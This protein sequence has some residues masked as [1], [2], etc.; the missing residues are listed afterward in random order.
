MKK[1]LPGQQR[2]LEAFIKAAQ[3]LAGLTTQQDIWSETGK[4]LVNFFGADVGA[5]E[6]GRA[7]RE[8][9]RHQWT[10]SKQFSSSRRDLEAATREIIAEAL[11]SG[12][13][14]TRIIFLPEALSLACFPV[15]RENQVVAVMLAGHG[16]SEALPRELL[17]V[18]L[19]MA[20]L[21]GT[22]VTRLTSERELREHREH[23][24]Q[25][26]K[27][28]TKELTKV[29]KQMQ[30]EISERKQAEKA[31]SRSEAYFR[32]LI[33][34]ASDMITILNADDIIRYESPSAER[35][36]G[37]KPSEMI[38]R[39]AFEFIHPDDLLMIR[40][41]GDR[42][43][44]IPG[45]TLSIEH[46][47]RHK[48]GSWRILE[49][50]VQN[51]L[52]N[53]AVKGIVVNSH[54][55]T[56][57]KMAEHDL[58]RERNHLQTLLDF[59]RR[60]DTH[61]K[62]IESFIIEEC[63][64]I[65]GSKL[66]FI[67]FIDEDETLMQTHF[68]SEKA[69]EECVIDFKPVE[70]SLVHAGIWAEAIRMHAP[71]IINDYSRP[72]PRKK[73][74]PEG[75]VAVK[76]LMSIPIVRE[77][78]AVA[79]AAVANKEQD[80]DE[81][82][83]LYLNLFLESVWDILKRKRAEEALSRSEAYFR[84]IIEN[85]S[86]II[87]ILNVDGIVRYSSPS[88]ER[89]AGLKPSELRDRNIFEYIHH[90]D[91]PAA[92]DLFMR[93]TQNPAVAL[94]GEI[95]LLHSDGTWHIFEVVARNMLENKAVKGIVINSHDIT[96]RKRAEAIL[97]ENTHF[98]QTL[99][100]AIPNPIFYK[101]VRGVYQ[102]CNLAFESYLGL[103]K[104]EIVG[105]SVYDISPREL[106]DRYHEKD[107]ALFRQGG[108]QTYES[109]VQYADGTLHDVI[110]NKATY[111]DTGGIVSGL[112]GVILDITARKQAEEKLRLLNEQLEYKIAERTRQLLE[113]QQELIRKEK[114]SILGQL[115]GTV[116][117]ELRNPLGVINNATY[118]LK[119]IMPE[120][121][122]TV[123]EY[124]DIIESEIDNSQR[125]ISDLLDFSRTKVPEI[126]QITPVTLVTRALGKCHMPENVEV[127]M[128]IPDTVPEVHV[129][130][131]QMGQVL[132]NLINNALQAMPKGGTLSISARLVQGSRSIVQG[133]EKENLEPSTLHHAPESDFIEISIS[134]K[135]EGISPENMNKL[136]QP[137]F[138]TKTK[139]IGLGLVVCK[140]L[141]EA[142]GGKIEVESQLEKGTRFTVLLPLNICNV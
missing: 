14:S 63:I 33:E 93:T 117:H 92:R 59:Y 4:V 103:S 7:D 99:T 109:S 49:M 12:F 52:E 142:N 58:L 128:D 87:T 75:H 138:T 90:D 16:M 119:T 53:E 45:G 98:L 56:M 101:D 34:N 5:F 32:S 17:N 100:D 15:T 122:D 28:R 131:F 50:F 77:A 110:F 41:A 72:D 130:P 42:S 107:M 121:N 94:S 37:Y 89:V 48:D 65:S 112:V 118:F 61:I 54:D 18:Y 13:L 88:L 1:P 11:E 21:V 47:M 133:S 140:N 69:M 71:L 55:I 74:Y 120:A 79:I 60:A 38:G 126:I 10:L 81:A 105:K 46:R 78:K 43:L 141:V 124:L 111:T 31:L 40:D 9:T 127:H 23:L 27:E 76:R 85:A 114:L 97:Q 125:I 19:A 39:N 3:Y 86:D 137:L 70:F 26:V 51:M 83:L 24:E 22:T 8:Y 6:E 73:G 115:A 82:D 64:R 134:D 30:G 44:R 66:G 80:Y 135:G 132:Q 68:W 106:A 123:K 20:G 116:G 62:D 108:L 91:L 136:F 84:S 2:Y 129:D 96:A 25:L 104:S 139:G 95:R 57:R 102:G 113:T 36:L 67:G 29:N 35:I